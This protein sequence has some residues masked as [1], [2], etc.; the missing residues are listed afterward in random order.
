MIED[1]ARAIITFIVSWLNSMGLCVGKTKK[2]KRKLM[3][4]LAPSI[5]PHTTLI[6]PIF[7]SSSQQV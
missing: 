1:R 2:L 3:P 6:I 4:S 5:L 7:G